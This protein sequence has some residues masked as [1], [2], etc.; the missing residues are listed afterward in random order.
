M[1]IEMRWSGDGT[2]G[3]IDAVFSPNSEDE[4][5]IGTLF[6]DKETWTKK[7]SPSSFAND[8]MA[9][10]LRRLLAQDVR[11]T[12]G[13]NL[14]EYMVP[15]NVV[16]LERMPLSPNGKVDRKR[17]PAPENT[18]SSVLSDY[19]AARDLVEELLTEIWTEVLGLDR[20]GIDDAFLDLG[21]HSILAVQI[22]ARLN[23]IFPFETPLREIFEA[24]TV[25]RLCE[26]LRERSTRA[27]LAAEEVC[28]TYREIEAMTD[29]EV[30][31]RLIR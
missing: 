29:D 7:T 11:A 16:T 26:G 6:A 31:A 3:L 8:P 1:R 21:G 12:L 22:Q 14:P 24:I 28:R 10:K 25:A 4:T 27:G 19:V 9:G 15:T 13:K 18:R 17:L 5:G 30:A 2:Q 20:V 23:E